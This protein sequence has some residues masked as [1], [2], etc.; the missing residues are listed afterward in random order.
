[1]GITKFCDVLVPN[2]GNVPDATNPLFVTFTA[3]RCARKT[4]TVEFN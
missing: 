1:M 2:A 4:A 3:A